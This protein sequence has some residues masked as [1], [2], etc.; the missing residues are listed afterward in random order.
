MKNIFTL[1]FIMFAIACYSLHD[2]KAFNYWGLNE[3]PISLSQS[4]IPIVGG[5]KFISEGEVRILTIMIKIEGYEDPNINTTDWPLD[6][7]PNYNF[8]E[9][10]LDPENIIFSGNNITRYYYEMSDGAF[11]MLGDMYYITVPQAVYEQFPTNNAQR[12]Y[13][14]IQYCYQQ[15]EQQILLN[16]DI[17]ASVYDQWTIGSNW[18]HQNTPDL[19]VDYT[20]VNFR[21]SLTHYFEDGYTGMSIIPLYFGS[22]LKIGRGSIQSSCAN[23]SFATGVMIHEMIHDQVESN[24]SGDHSGR[25]ARLSPL[26][27]NQ[28]GWG[29]SPIGFTAYEKYK[30]GYLDF[31]ELNQN[32]S[33]VDYTISDYMTTN[34]AILVNIPNSS[35]GYI[36]ENRQSFDQIWDKA[37]AKGIYIYRVDFSERLYSYELYDPVM[38]P[39]P[40]DGSSITNGDGY[41]GHINLLS[42][43]GRFNFSTNKS[44]A[45][46][47][48]DL[49]IYKEEPNPKGYD[50]RDFCIAHAGGRAYCSYFSNL[51]PPKLWY[52]PVY[53]PESTL[54]N[55]GPAFGSEYDTFSVGYNN[56]ISPWSNP[57]IEPDWAEDYQFAC[58]VIDENEQ[59][60]EITLRFYFD[61][62]D[63][64][65][66]S[67]PLQ[68]A[69]DQ[70][71]NG[72]ETSFYHFQKLNHSHYELFIRNQGAETWNMISSFSVQSNEYKKTFLITDNVPYGGTLNL[73]APE[74][75]IVAV[76]QN[77]KRSNDSS[78]ITPDPQYVISQDR[79]FRN[80]HVGTGTKLTIH[81]GQTSIHAQGVISLAEG[82]ELNIRENATI[83]INDFV[84]VTNSYQ[85]CTQEEQPKLIISGL[86]INNGA[87]IFDFSTSEIGLD[88][89][90]SNTSLTMANVEFS[91]CEITI[92]DSNVI[93]QNLELADSPL[94]IENGTQV[95]QD[96]STN[97]LLS[98]YGS[99]LLVIK[100][101]VFTGNNGGLLMND[102]G[103]FVDNCDFINNNI[104]GIWIE[105]CQVI[106]GHQ[107]SRYYAN[108]INNSTISENQQDGIRV[109][110]SDVRLYNC[111]IENNLGKGVMA[112]GPTI[113]D[114]RKDPLN[115]TGNSSRIANNQY[116]EIDQIGHCINITNGNNYI[117]DNT[118]NIG[119][120][121]QYL[122]HTYCYECTNPNYDVTMNYWGYGNVQNVALA[123]PIERFDHFHNYNTT[124]VWNPL[125]MPE[126]PPTD[127]DLFSLAID[128][129]SS[130]E[131][132]LGISF[133]KQLISEYPNSP[134][135]KH[136]AQYLFALE[137]D[138]Q[139][140]KDYY[141]TEPRFQYDGQIDHT[142]DYLTKHCDIK[143]GNYEEAINWFENEIANP[144]TAYDSLVAIID[145]G[146]IYT[147]M[148]NQKNP[149]M[150]KLTKFIP[151]SNQEYHNN[152]DYLITNLSNI[153]NNEFNQTNENNDGIEVIDEVS[154]LSCYPNPFN[155]TTTISFNLTKQTQVR[156]SVYNIKG[157]IVETL[158]NESLTAG[159][160]EITWNGT[161]RNG[162]KVASGVY[163]YRISTDK[164]TITNKIV[165]LK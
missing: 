154:F 35:R 46:T 1:I 122:I 39:E 98:V 23:F 105:N 61:N 108:S 77:N 89:Y 22:T 48:N 31:I 100:E 78:I 123:P 85:N 32:T 130:G 41:D 53:Y 79:S 99:E 124:P 127:G 27:S 9:T 106:S 140:L 81:S 86:L 95:I 5:Q 101:S 128:Y 15:V 87:S 70:V 58:E 13:Q 97:A 34:S 55:Y 96:V 20:F 153:I 91:N 164:T 67:K 30:L 131:I 141:L 8:F 25:L 93:I 134:H 74:Y 144:R 120:W 40:L 118:Y 82:S 83:A 68:L 92:G 109:F 44:T 119:S 63:Q 107:Q 94:L 47:I 51:V 143:L 54:P 162:S 121:D 71:T 111:S 45:Q 33:I 43:K 57:Q 7:D 158:I 112:F 148:E 12:K 142:I 139:A 50:E 75:K 84:Q 159:T 76:D 49:R 151:K 52:D 160:H 115:T 165:M 37:F 138:K 136:S 117:I 161:N 73:N 59:T 116:Q 126:Y 88:F 104:Y 135:F 38:K 90:I 4:D 102:T 14:T 156:L 150:G 145:L 2:Q 137:Q 147:L 6:S 103:F 16:E 21:S 56:I 24:G 65:V 60:G 157:Q 10:E 149:Y 113:L 163:F 17:D 69:I 125:M 28:V 36:I 132:D 133:F 110:R 80:L 18:D 29:S 26:N 66:P 42:A 19:E 129:A 146:Y 3:D 72:L 62:V 152:V 11:I 155:P 114:I 64:C